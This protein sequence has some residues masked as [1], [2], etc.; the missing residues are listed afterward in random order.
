MSRDYYV[1]ILSNRNNTVLYVGVTNDLRRRVYEHRNH[2]NGGFSQRYG[3][4]KLVYYEGLDDPQNAIARE[5][6][7]KGGSRQDK[8]ALINRGSWLWQDLGEEL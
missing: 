1:Y 2:L 7:I 5:K 3:V 6:Q 8:E 4:H